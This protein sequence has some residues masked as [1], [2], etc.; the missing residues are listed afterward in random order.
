MTIENRAADTANTAYRVRFTTDGVNFNNSSVADPIPVGRQILAA[1]G[2]RDVENYSLFAILLNG[3]F[4]DVRLDETFDL[5]G[6]GTEAFAYFETDRSFNFTIEQ[7]QMS[8]GKNLISGKALRTLAGI[9][10]RYTI[11]LEVRGG[12]DRPIADTDLVDLSGKGIERF[13][14]VICETTEGLAALPSTDRQFLENNGLAYEIVGDG[15]ASGVVIKNF[16]LP[17]GKFDHDTV[18]IMIQ[19]PCG[20]PDA[21]VDMFYTMPW[22][23]LKASGRYANCADVSHQFAGQNWQRWSRHADWRAGIDGIRTMVARAELAFA[24]AA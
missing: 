13:I 3:E 2:I 22:I 16:P 4:E 5:R 23:K 19:L 12:H 11:Y 20:Y 1:A 9:D 8:W 18:D 10:E 14:T 24:K 21:S 6:K 17:P 7:R 15:E